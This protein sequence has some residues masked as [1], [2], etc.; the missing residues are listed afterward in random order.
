MLWALW[1]VIV[2]QKQKDSKAIVKI[3]DILKYYMILY[4]KA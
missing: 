4:N 2:I 1:M 3:K